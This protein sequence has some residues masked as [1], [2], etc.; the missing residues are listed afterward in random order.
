M[1]TNSA[2]EKWLPQSVLKVKTELLVA[3]G[4]VCC[5]LVAYFPIFNNGFVTWDTAGYVLQN[6][7]IKQLNW[8]NL[9]WMFGSY[10][11]SNWHPITWLSHAIDYYLYGLNSAGHHTTSLIFHILN[12][13][14]VYVI[15]RNIFAITQS[16]KNQWI[17]GVAG[18]LF[19]VHPQHVESVAWVAERKDVLCAF[20][21]LLVIFWYL[22]HG[23]DSQ[24]KYRWAVFLSISTALALM[25]KPMAVSIPLVLLLLDIYPLAR[26]KFIDFHA[27]EYP[28]Q[29]P[30]VM[31]VLEK[32]YLFAM[33]FAVAIIAFIVQYHSGAVASMEKVNAVQRLLNAMNSLFLYISK[34]LIPVNLSPFYQFPSYIANYGSIQSFVP[35]VGFIGVSS[36]SVWLWKKRQPYWL[37]AWLYYCIVLLPVVGIVQ[38]GDQAAADRY[39][40]LPTIPFY[41]LVCAG[42]A[43]ICNKSNMHTKRWH[44]AAILIGVLVLVLS[45]ITLT[46][47]Q[48]K[49]WKDD[50]KFWQYT[51]EHAPKSGLVR[52]NFGRTL[53][54]VGQI[55]SAI[56]ELE[57]AV[58]LRNSATIHKWLGDAY[59]ARGALALAKQH[60]L[61]SLALNE[62]KKFV[63]VTDIFIGIATVAIRQHDYREAWKFA[64]QVIQLDPKNSKAILLL[65][66]IKEEN[67]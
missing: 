49:I 32:W 53:Y 64:K 62:D 58:K 67:N 66:Q 59:L 50:L 15:T 8:E 3:A 30:I 7:H 65:D 38:I 56:N 19:A 41:I 24:K 28:S 2:V 10:H 20:F 35:V 47:Q 54:Q 18:I 57:A 23:R 63:K 9:G 51:T 40:Y 34:W 22:R 4:I 39:A 46:Q 11:M 12:S 33:V 5:G 61:M 37:I 16:S 29:K 44:K 43:M 26:S 13:L 42:I 52:S 48:T 21:Y 17:P 45:L 6:E 14:L 27:S 31:L 25:A 1:I 36:I 60:Y 55:E